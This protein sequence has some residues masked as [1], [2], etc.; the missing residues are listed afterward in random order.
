MKAGNRVS[1]FVTILI[2]VIV[3]YLSKDFPKEVS[4]APGPGFYPTILSWML[5]ALGIIL[6]AQSFILKQIDIKGLFSSK[7][8]KFIYKICGIGVIYCMMLP[9][10]GFIVTTLIYLAVLSYI[11]GLRKRKFLILL[12]IVAT[13][14]IVFIFE[15]LFQI[16]L[17]KQMLF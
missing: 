17:P 1:A 5:I 7:K 3:L 13:A 12:P 10:I 6:L 15:I 14:L 8:N 4:S 2:G 9:L 11:L 16:P